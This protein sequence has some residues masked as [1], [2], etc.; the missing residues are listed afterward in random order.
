MLTSKY[1]IFI[2]KGNC[3]VIKPSEMA[4]NVA[5]LLEDIVPRYLDNVS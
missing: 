2:F 4:V 3:A 1:Y 5:K